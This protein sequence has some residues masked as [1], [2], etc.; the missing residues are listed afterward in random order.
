MKLSIEKDKKKNYDI[1][2]ECVRFYRTLQAKFQNR[3]FAEFDTQKGE[4]MEVLGFSRIRN[5]VFIQS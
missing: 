3:F 2:E 1:T 4:W 5:F